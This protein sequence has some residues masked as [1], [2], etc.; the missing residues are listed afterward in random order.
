MKS[1]AQIRREEQALNPDIFSQTLDE[2]LMRIPDVTLDIARLVGEKY[3][4][5]IEIAYEWSWEEAQDI[6]ELL[7]IREEKSTRDELKRRAQ[8]SDA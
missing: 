3:G 1:D 6:L 8:G 4:S 7:D 2:A 5:Y